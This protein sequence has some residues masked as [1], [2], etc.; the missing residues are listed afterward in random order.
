[1]AT[2]EETEERIKK[3]EEKLLMHD[4]AIKRLFDL[5]QGTIDTQTKQ[6]KVGQERFQTESNER[7]NRIMKELGYKIE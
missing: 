5:F 4:K 6:S 7:L 1:M 3:L 2:I